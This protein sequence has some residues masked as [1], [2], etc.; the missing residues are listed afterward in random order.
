MKNVS[1]NAFL[2]FWQVEPKEK[3]NVIVGLTAIGIAIWIV[4][5]IRAMKQASSSS[6]P[7]PDS[8]PPLPS[9]SSSSMLPSSK[10]PLPS[11]P[12]TTVV[13]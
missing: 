5:K 1:L 6:D 11:N 8:A 9:P 7:D 2:A 4:F 3:N 13:V 12:S 10:S